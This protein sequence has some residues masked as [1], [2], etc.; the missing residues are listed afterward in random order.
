VKTKILTPWS[1]LYYSALKYNIRVSPSKHRATFIFSFYTLFFYLTLTVLVGFQLWLGI[2]CTVLLLSHYC[3]PHIAVIT[4]QLFKLKPS[5]K[6]CI[7][8]NFILSDSGECQFNHKN[9]LQLSANSQINLWGY[10]LVFTKSDVALKQY[11]IFKDSLSSEDQAR[12]ART[13]L[14][15]K[16]SPELKL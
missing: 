9:I 11:F 10:W 13:I 16:N 3:H 7:A 6:T 14:R 15:M 8:N 5:I 1:N 2:L 12:I 4:E